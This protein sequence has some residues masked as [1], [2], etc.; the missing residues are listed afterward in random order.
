L[1]PEELRVLR[2]GPCFLLVAAPYEALARGL[3]LLEPGGLERL[4]AEAS[5]PRGRGRTAVV[6]LEGRSERLHLRP[7]Q[8]GGALAGLWGDRLLGPGRPSAELRT[9]ARLRARGAPVPR[10]V[11]VAARRRRG[12]FWRAALATLHEEN[13][14]DGV[15]FLAGTPQPERLLRACAAA[16]SAVRALHE[17]G[18]QHRDLHVKNVLLR[19]E[20]SEMRAL[21]IDLD[22]ARLLPEL[23]P[24]ARMAEIMRLYR[25]LV[26]RGLEAPVGREGCQAFF[27]AYTAGDAALGAALLTH[28]PRERRRLA[29]HRLG[30]RLGLSPAADTRPGAGP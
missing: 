27:S 4:L 20:G 10:P 30:H 13:S 19:E 5:G 8:H 24:R 2:A 15:A 21:L 11:L 29:L 16:G 12:P 3:G 7:V 25:S 23:G 22:R 9:N 6:P 1:A 17:A 18:G 28:L 14:V 26:K